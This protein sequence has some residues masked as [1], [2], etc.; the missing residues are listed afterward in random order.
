MEEHQEQGLITFNKQYVINKKDELIKQKQK[1]EILQRMAE[2]KKEENK[3]FGD[4]RS[5]FQLCTRTEYLCTCL[6][7]DTLFAPYSKRRKIA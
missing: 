4:D 1:C 7:T 6:C 3:I 2:R 5:T